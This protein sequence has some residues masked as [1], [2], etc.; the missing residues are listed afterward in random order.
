MSA[1][2]LLLLT[3]CGINLDT[4]FSTDDNFKG[5][6]VITCSINKNDLTNLNRDLT[7]IDAIIKENCPEIMTYENRSTDQQ[8]SY[9]FVISFDSFSDYKNKTERCLNFAPEIDYYYNDSPFANGLLYKENFTSR[10]LMAW[11]SESLIKKGFME[12]SE[13]EKIWNIEDTNFTFDGTDYETDQPISIDTM[14]YLPL[15]S[16][17]IYTTE[18]G[19]GRYKQSV[20]FQIPSES[21]DLDRSGIESYLT[22]N[23]DPRQFQW[24]QTSTK[25]GRSYRIT[26]SA[27]NQ[28]ELNRLTKKVLH[29]SASLSGQSSLDKKQTFQIN[30]NCRLKYSFNALR[31]SAD[32]NVHY[33][34]YFKTSDGVIP[35]HTKSGSNGYYLL[36]EGNSTNCDITF[37]V[38]RPQT[39]SSYRIT[40]VF[41]DQDNLI[42]ELVLTGTYLYSEQDIKLLS[43]EL[44]KLGF[45]KVQYTS[46]GQ[47]LLFISG[48]PK[49]ITSAYNSF[50]QTNNLLHAK[51]NIQKTRSSRKSSVQDCID[52][53]SLPF[54]DHAEGTYYFIS[55][56][57]EL[58]K[59]VSLSV[60]NKE[61]PLTKLQAL[62]KSSISD[63]SSLSDFKGEY[64][65]NVNSGTNI[66]FEYSGGV[67]DMYNIVMIVFAGGMIIATLIIAWMYKK[68]ITF[69]RK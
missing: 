36:E 53:S 56:S 11:F 50:L 57:P 49:E 39:F 30:D 29:G 10:D 33:K 27:D 51:T 62:E 32:G 35:S 44:K 15:D 58:I 22:G 38:N 26:Y 8:I 14:S 17:S 21:L 63:D 23:L 24:K 54:A 9:S 59:Q 64:K 43:K 41:N 6:R 5:T 67:T 31:S 18:L 40:T 46:D 28:K 42:R 2:L 61:I 20:V 65:A 16:V 1:G 48:T 45:E 60:N 13:A 47:L 12:E 25:A 66:Q 19:S 7:S 68:K 3:A 55:N 4:V 52:L 69:F 37:Q 34:I